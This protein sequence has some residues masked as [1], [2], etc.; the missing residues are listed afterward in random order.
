MSANRKFQITDVRSG[1]AITVRVVT[2]AEK[3]ELAGFQ[4]EGD[5]RV[6]KVRLMASPASD[7][8]A[9][10]ELIEF[11]AGVIGV[12]PNRVEIVAGA[13]GREKIV[14]IEGVSSQQVNE[15]LNVT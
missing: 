5:V 3:T 10:L 1:A 14:T 12:A 13:G 11:L 7:P 15:A 6:V 2:Q 9:N 8:A 4:D